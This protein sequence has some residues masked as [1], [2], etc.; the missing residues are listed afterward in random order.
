VPYRHTNSKGQ[1]YYL[2]GKEVTLP[3]GRPRRIYYFAPAPK[4]GEALEDL[5]A[6]AQVFEHPRTGLPFV[7]GTGAAPAGGA[8]GRA[9]ARSEQGQT[10]EGE[11]AR[12]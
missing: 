2:H 6:G 10:A 9:R 12:G 4:S 7:R 5:P 11:P 3:N 1:T 8:T